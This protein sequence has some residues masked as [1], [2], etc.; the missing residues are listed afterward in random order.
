MNKR[1]ITIFTAT[2][3]RADLILRL[4]ESL[5][6]QSVRNFEWLIVDDGSTDNTEHVVKSL[7]EKDKTF[8]IRYYK[9]TNQGKHIAINKGLQEAKG[10]Y[11][12]IVDSDDRLPEKSLEIINDKINLI[13]NKS[14]IA[15]VVGLKCFFDKSVVGSNDLKDDLICSLFKYRYYYKYYGDRAEVIK[16]SIFK[17]YLFPKFENEKFVPESIVWNQIA[18]E[19]ELLF[20]SKNV[21]ECEYQEDGLSAS[22]MLLRRKNPIGATSLYINLSKV[23]TIPMI[24][25]CKAHINFWRFYWCLPNNYKYSQLKKIRLDVYLF[26]S[27]ILGTLLYAKDSI[28]IKTK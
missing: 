14:K 21:Y 22:S 1:L 6:S 7:I 27:L 12:F 26:V 18:A 19:H 8:D 10:D 28:S 17:K 3:N 16:T 24:Y 23:K 11:F 4:Y 25:I 2:Y 15:G 9:Q 13:N 20:F 5:Q